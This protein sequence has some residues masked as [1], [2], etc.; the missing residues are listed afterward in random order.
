MGV[1]LTTE[2]LA[3]QVTRC[4][5]Q[6]GMTV[7]GDDAYLALR[8]LRTLSVRLERHQR[9]AQ[10]LTDW[11]ARQP[12]VA[13]ILYPARPGDA[14]HALWQRDFTGACGLFGLVLHPQPDE[15]VRAL[16]DGMER[17]RPAAAHSRGA[18][19]SGRHDRRPRRRL[20]ENARRRG[21]ARGSLKTDNAICVTVH[22][23]FSSTF[24][25]HR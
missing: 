17:G 20:R 12:E 15:A 19:A 13:Q 22:H 18:R 11:L 9:N 24:D 8:G 21:R 10:V 14:G 6:L 2:A 25:H 3:Q 4:Y 1:I 23:L 7:S 16:L 5:R